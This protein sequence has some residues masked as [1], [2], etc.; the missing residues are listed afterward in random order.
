MYRSDFKI[1]SILNIIRI[2]MYNIINV[3]LW[4][5]EYVAPKNLTWRE[6]DQYT[7][8]PNMTSAKRP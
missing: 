4:L 1:H 6:R 2:R 7:S 3:F 5:Y 8:L